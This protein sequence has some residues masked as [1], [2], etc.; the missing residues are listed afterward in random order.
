MKLVTFIQKDDVRHIGALVNNDR[1]IVILQ[2]GAKE[3]NGEPSPFFTDMLAFLRGGSAARDLAQ[4]VVEY[5]T[6]QQQPDAVVSLDRVIL[7]APVPRPESIRDSMAFE[8]HIINCTRVIGLKRFAFV[9]E[10]IERTFG[11]K[12][13][14]AYRF[15]KEANRGRI[16]HLNLINFCRSVLLR[17]LINKFVRLHPLFIPHNIIDIKLLCL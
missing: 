8:Q 10:W 14:L 5:V 12:R 16:N 11:R 3:V 7:L 17:Y 15:N 6:S 9:D 1:T 13:S 2:K 4:A